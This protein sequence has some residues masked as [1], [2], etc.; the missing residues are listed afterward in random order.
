MML[1]KIDHIMISPRLEVCMY[2]CHILLT[3]KH[4][5]KGCIVPQWRELG[6]ENI[7]DLKQCQME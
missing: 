3:D 7:A 5:N 1:K 6:Q 2:K 4:P